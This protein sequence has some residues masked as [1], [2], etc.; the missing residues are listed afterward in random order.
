MPS[1]T[2]IGEIRT[3]YIVSEARELEVLISGNVRIAAV[4][5]KAVAKVSNEIEI[6]CEFFKR[7]GGCKEEVCVQT[8]MCDFRPCKRNVAIVARMDIE[9]KCV[10][11][12]K[13]SQQRATTERRDSQKP[14]VAQVSEMRD[15]SE[16]ESVS[17]IA[18]ATVRENLGEAEPDVSVKSLTITDGILRMTHAAKQ[19]CGDGTWILADTRA[20][21][22]PV[23]MMKGQRIPAGT[24]PCKLKLAI[25][26]VEVWAFADGWVKIVTGTELPIITKFA[27]SSLNATR[28]GR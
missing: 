12:Q 27:E 10:F 6:E 13:Q 22:E 11:D 24:R 19:E 23:A 14:K 16:K 20:T 1:S 7:D 9:Q 8:C 2:W 21:H 25:G 5:Q 3:S 28:V 4:K 26:H 15:E 17:K 18:S